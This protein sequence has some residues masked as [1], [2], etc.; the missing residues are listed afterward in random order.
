MYNS[1]VTN[2]F[3]YI[4][5]C[6]QNKLLPTRSYVELKDNSNDPED[7]QLII[8]QRIDEHALRKRAHWL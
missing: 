7:F 6:F 1:I 5:C 3:E 2:N 8:E 4:K